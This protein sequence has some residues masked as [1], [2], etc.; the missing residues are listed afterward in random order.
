[1]ESLYVLAGH[2]VQ[3]G[4]PKPDAHTLHV[5]PVNPLAQEVVQVTASFIPMPSVVADVPLL[6]LTV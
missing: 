5:E 2:V 3:F 4:P 6:L 1:M